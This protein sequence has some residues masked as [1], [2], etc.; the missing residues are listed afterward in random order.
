MIRRQGRRRWKQNSGYH[1]RSLVETT[2]FRLKTLFGP[3]VQARAFPQQ[4]TELFLKAAALNRMTHLGMPESSR[5]V[6]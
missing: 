1:R 5:L 6:A 4:A 3:S 2:F